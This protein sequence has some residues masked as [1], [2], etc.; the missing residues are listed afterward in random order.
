MKNKLLKTILMLSKCFLYGLVLQTLLLNLVVALDAN[1][2]YKNIEEVRVTLT[3][4]QLSLDQFFKEVQR[5]TPFKFS[6]EYRDVDRQQSVTFAKKEGPVID[7]LREAA[8]QSQLS[9]RQVNHGI[10]VLKRNDS[11]VEV[12]ADLDPV[13]ISGT[14]VDGNGEPIP[15][16]TVSVPAT[17]IGTV[18]D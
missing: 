14:V 18:T 2:Q 17:S 6:Y 5:Q 7:F 13:S 16:V 12:I 10:D 4:D 15:G 3:A 11:G 1:G 9:F 8:E